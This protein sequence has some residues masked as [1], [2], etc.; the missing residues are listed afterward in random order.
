MEVV[1]GPTT[2][3]S[4]AALLCERAVDMGAAALVLAQHAHSTLAQ[5][6]VGSTVASAAQA[7][8]VPLIVVP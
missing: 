4:V 1:R 2:A 8:T 3:K 7:S 6:F 5:L